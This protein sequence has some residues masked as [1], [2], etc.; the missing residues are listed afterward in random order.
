[1]R[2]DYN[3]NDYHE[4]HSRRRVPNMRNIGWLVSTL[5]SRMFWVIFIHDI[6][7]VGKVVLNVFDRTSLPYYPHLWMWEHIGWTSI[8]V[9]IMVTCW[10]VYRNGPQ[11]FGLKYLAK[12]M[13]R[14]E[15]RKLVRAQ[16]M[17]ELHH[18]AKRIDI[19]GRRDVDYYRDH[20]IAK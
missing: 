9:M 18:R 6:G 1:M 19:S 3:N 13:A 12:W 7:E 4:R 5:I 2:S 17:K 11:V 16:R 20:R 14:E 15:F 8:I 10:S